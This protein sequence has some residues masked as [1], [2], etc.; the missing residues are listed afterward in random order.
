MGYTKKTFD[1]A[2]QADKVEK[3][4]SYLKNFIEVTKH[5][6][7]N[8]QD[9]TSIISVKYP[10]HVSHKEQQPNRYKSSS[11]SSKKAQRIVQ[12]ANWSNEKEIRTVTKAFNDNA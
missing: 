8:T 6:L 9:S 10:L 12:S 3:F 2:I 11:E 7:V 1:L 5:D 4:I